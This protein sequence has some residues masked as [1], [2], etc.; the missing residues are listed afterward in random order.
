MKREFNTFNDAYNYLL[1][2]ILFNYDEN[3][4]IY[5]EEEINRRPKFEKHNYSFY[6]INPTLDPLK[7]KDEK[8]NK[9][10]ENYTQI[11]KQLFDKG[12][13]IGLTKYGNIWKNITNPD[14]TI[15]ANYG[16]MVYH[17][18]DAGN[19]IYEPDKELSSQWEWAKSRLIKRLTCKQAY[20]HFNRPSHQ[21]S[22]NRDQPCAMFIQ[23]LASKNGEESQLNL[24]G[25]MRSNDAVR[26]TP[27]NI[28]YFIELLYRMVKELQEYYPNLKIGYYY[29]HATS[30]HIYHHDVN[31]VKK[32]LKLI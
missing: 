30:I 23:F 1:N 8:R 18:K 4:T 26:G 5:E 7:T 25:N 12:D 32:M 10:M 3:N 19:L 9:I 27:Y 21:W 11:E 13:C 2:D 14:G 31:I 20:M 22:N 29:H 17:I 15:N 24:C 16:Y 28:M 6:I